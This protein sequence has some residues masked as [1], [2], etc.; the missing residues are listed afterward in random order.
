MSN[1]MIYYVMGGTVVA[2]VII[3]I[4]YVILSK[5]MQKSEYKRIQKLQQGTKESN[6]ST[7]ILFQK[8]YLTY[9]KIPFL[10]RYVLKLRRRLEI[11]NIDDE[12]IT[13][14]ESAKI[15]TKALAVIAPVMVI[16]IIIAKSNAL[17]MAIL[18][19]FELFMIDT[20]IDGSVDKI[21]N[22]LLKEQIEFFSEIRHAYH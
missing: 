15:L 22:V 1:N 10:K 4:A 5:K 6:F 17:L 12:Y 3:I 11:I 18:L 20:L 21:D 16:T 13:R 14:K 8:L 2:F 19:M 9:I 7:E